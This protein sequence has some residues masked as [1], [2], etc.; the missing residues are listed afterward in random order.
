M[1]KQLRGQIPTF[2]ESFRD[3]EIF[4]LGCWKKHTEFDTNKK[5][6]FY[7]IS[8]CCRVY[9]YFWISRPSN[10]SDVVYKKGIN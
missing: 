10:L 3:A 9:T 4:D 6:Y 2:K 7:I 1:K 8:C 5:I